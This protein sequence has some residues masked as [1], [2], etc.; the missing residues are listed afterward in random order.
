MTELIECVEKPESLLA[1]IRCLLRPSG[2]ALIT[3]PNKSVFPI[4]AYWKSENPPSK[5]PFKLYSTLM[6]HLVERAVNSGSGTSWK[7][8]RSSQPKSGKY[9]PKSQKKKEGKN[10]CL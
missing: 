3:T 9:S 1:D 5:K 4:G 6:D 2:F 10:S 7:G 8:H